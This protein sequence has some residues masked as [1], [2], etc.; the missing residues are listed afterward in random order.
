[1]VLDLVVLGEARDDQC[2]WMQWQGSRELVSN[3]GTS[4]FE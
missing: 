3:T 2:W 4:V 1:M